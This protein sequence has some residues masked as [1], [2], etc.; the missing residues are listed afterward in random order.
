MQKNSNNSIDIDKVLREGKSFD[1]TDD[2][3]IRQIENEAILLHTSTGTYYNLSE[4]S[5]Q[6]WEALQNKQP[7]EPVVKQITDE[8]EVEYSQVIEDLR[9]FLQDLQKFGIVRKSSEN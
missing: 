9:V 5:I 7:L 1:V 8:Y 4:T 2:I 3:L 6:F